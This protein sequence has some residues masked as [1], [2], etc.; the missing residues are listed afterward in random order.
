MSADDTGRTLRLMWR[1]F[2]GV[3]IAGDGLAHSDRRGIGRVSSGCEG[4]RA[5]TAL[6]KLQMMCKGK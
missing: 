2:M 5:R 1:N 3:S 4:G 6:A